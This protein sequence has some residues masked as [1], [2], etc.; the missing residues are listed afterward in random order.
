MAALV[1]TVKDSDEL[2]FGLVNPQ[3]D[4]G[5]E[6]VDNEHLQAELRRDEHEVFPQRNGVGLLQWQEGQGLPLLLP[7]P[8]RPHHHEQPDTWM[9]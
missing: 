6:A 8:P 2:T 9:Y 5:E 4:E 1:Y 3:G 7:P